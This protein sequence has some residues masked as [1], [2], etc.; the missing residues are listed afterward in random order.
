MTKLRFYLISTLMALVVS[1]L[2]GGVTAVLS[3]EKSDS[4]D[5]VLAGASFDYLVV[6]SNKG[7]DDATTVEVSDTLPAE[8]L[9]AAIVAPAGWNCTTPAVGSSGTVT[10]TNATM[11]VGSAVFTITVTADP[12]TAAGTIFAN[13]ATV[14]ATSTDPAPGDESDTEFTTIGPTNTDLAVAIV[15]TPDP[16]QGGEPV[17]Y[18]VTASLTDN[19][20]DAEFVELL[21]PPAGGGFVSLVAPGGWSCTQPMVGA[22]GQI[23]C[24]IATLPAS[25]SEVFT[26][27]VD[28]PTNLPPTATVDQ[29]VSFQLESA[30]RPLV[31]SAVATTGIV[32]PATLT[33]TKVVSGDTW[34]GSAITYTVVVTNIGPAGQF[35]N[36][37]DELLD[38]LPPELELV[39]ASATTGVAAVDLGTNT[40]TW[41]GSLAVAATATITINATVAGG[42][43]GDI[44]SNQATLAFDVT[45]VG[46]NTG[47]GQSDDPGVGGAADPTDFVIAS[48]AEL[49]ATKVVTGGTLAAG[50]TVLYTIEL[51][52]LGPA[53]QLDNLGDELVDVLPAEL[54]LVAASADVGTVGVDLGTNTVTWNG[55]LAAG[56]T[57]TI[58][59]E[60]AIVAGLAHG[61]PVVNQ[62]TLSFD[63]DGNGVNEGTGVSDDPHTGDPDDPTSF[64]VLG[65]ALEI[66]V[67]DPRGLVALSVLLAGLGL[68]VLR[69]S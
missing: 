7:P 43:P 58:E 28:A 1:P 12:A 63:A 37:T 30:G 2:W 46:D 50:G 57:A 23:S 13:T 66:P 61:T 18:T 14:T 25:A 44:V 22:V 32:S 49:V 48:P 55:S 42:S 36:A 5:P 54:D 11:M 21:L 8:A 17:T 38:V 4:A 52:N 60:A 3:L 16:V 24:S 59:V 69:R 68:V 15:G 40:V 62:A 64:T 33:A 9:F 19:I 34:V 53:P 31:T 10:C 56:A 26:V 51:R 65:S 39:A 29:A 47:A 45:G 20:F 6:V 67:L 41:N 27:V 35:D